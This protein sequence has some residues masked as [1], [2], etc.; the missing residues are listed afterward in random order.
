MG[1]YDVVHVQIVDNFARTLLERWDVLEQDLVRVAASALESWVKGEPIPPDHFYGPD[2]LK[3][4]HDWYPSASDGSPILALDPYTFEVAVDEPY[5]TVFE[6]PYMR[7]AANVCAVDES[8]ST[9][10]R[11]SEPEKRIVFGF[12]ADV[13]PGPL[14]LGYHQFKNKIAEAGIRA[15]VSML[16]IGD[17]PPDVD[18]LFVPHELAAAAAGAAP[19]SRIE[20]LD[21]FQNNPV[22]NSIVEAWR[23]DAGS[24]TP[25]GGALRS[26]AG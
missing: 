22:Y 7:Q 17:L 4:D 10:R 14:I 11:E 15:T 19:N 25:T 5:L 2:F 16:A 20:V 1:P 26:H 21:T 3:L 12:T 13:F 8:V 9:E 6:W 24:E 18:V 23:G